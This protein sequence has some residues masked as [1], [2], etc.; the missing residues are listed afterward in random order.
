MPFRP[1]EEIGATF[2]DLLLVDDRAVFRFGKLLS[3]PA[4]P[5][6]A[7]EHDVPAARQANQRW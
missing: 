3:T 6:P 2:T 4:E 1:G 7:V 5:E